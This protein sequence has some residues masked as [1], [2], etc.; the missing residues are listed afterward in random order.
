MET[1]DIPYQISAP[2]L[3]TARVLAR[4]FDWVEKPG[5]DVEPSIENVAIIIDARTQAFRFK[6]AMKDFLSHC[7]WLDNPDSGEYLEEKL[8]EVRGYV[9]GIVAFQKT[10]PRFEDQVQQ[11]LSLAGISSGHTKQ[12]LAEQRKK[13]SRYEVDPLA[14]YATQMLMEHFHFIEKRDGA[15]RAV[16]RHIALLIGMCTRL[17]KLE[18]AVNLMCAQMIGQDEWSLRKNIEVVRRALRAVDLGAMY[19]PSYKHEVPTG[20]GR[21]SLSAKWNG[22]GAYQPSEREQR[23]AAQIKEVLAQYKD[24]QDKHRVMK[25]LGEIR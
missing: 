4:H 23:R 17:H 7:N 2:A 8:D 19:M 20:V 18:D 10:L 11:K 14:L 6:A 12:Q 24:E 5:V 13:A 16:D 21:V 3:H 1:K 15:I 9:E 22:K 25:M